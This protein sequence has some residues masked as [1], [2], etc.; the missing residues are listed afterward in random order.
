MAGVSGWNFTVDGEAD[1]KVISSSFQ[2]STMY[3]SDYFLS[4]GNEGRR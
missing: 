2:I 3:F 4:R 1:F